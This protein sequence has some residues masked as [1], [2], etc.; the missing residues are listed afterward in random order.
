MEPKTLRGETEEYMKGLPW[1]GNVR[2]LENTCRWITVMA[3]S[4]G[5]SGEAASRTAATTNH[6]ATAAAKDS[7]AP[8]TTGRRRALLAPWKLAVMA[9]KMS[10][11]SSPSRKTIIDELKT[12]VP[13]LCGP[14]TSVGS[15]G[16]VLAY[17]RSGTRSATAWALG[18]AGDRPADEILTAGRN[19]GYDLSHL[20]PMLRG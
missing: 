3:S 15:T 19:A 20:A 18:Q 12:T 8:S 14:R 13:S 17:C 11:A 16:P 6:V 4:R 1:Q 9:A 10:T 2:Q 5:P 7:D